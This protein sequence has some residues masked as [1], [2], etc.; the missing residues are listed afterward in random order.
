MKASEFGKSYSFDFIC[1]F[2]TLDVYIYWTNHLLSNYV[3][4]EH[5]AK[6]SPIFLVGHCLHLSHMPT[7]SG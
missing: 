7:K 5:E 6:H 2:V 4:L 3:Y 1:F